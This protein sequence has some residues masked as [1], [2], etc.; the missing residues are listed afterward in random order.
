M[1]SKDCNV[2]RFYPKEGI[3]IFCLSPCILLVTCFWLIGF[4][5]VLIVTTGLLITGLALWVGG[6]PVAILL[7]PSIYL[8]CWLS[9]LV[10]LPTCYVVIWITGLVLSVVLTIATITFYALSG[11]LLAVQVPVGFVKHNLLNPAEMDLSIINGLSRRFEQSWAT[12]WWP[13]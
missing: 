2:T 8:V 12:W 1:G 3:E 7:P 10:L 9:L 13:C 6:W 11:P 5:G 4:V